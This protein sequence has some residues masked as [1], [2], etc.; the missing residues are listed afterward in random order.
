[1]NHKLISAGVLIFACL[2]ILATGRVNI[3]NFEKVQSSLEQM[4]ED[5]LVVKGL[6]FDLSAH[7]HKKEIA[8]LTGDKTFFESENRLVNSQIET[9]LKTFRETYLTKKEEIV[10]NEFSLVIDQLIALES[11]TGLDREQWPSPREVLRFQ[12]LLNE[13]KSQMKTLSG[14]QLAEGERKVRGGERAVASMQQ[15]ESLEL[16]SVGVLV[17]LVFVLLWIPSGSVKP[18]RIEGSSVE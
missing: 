13:L 2:L 17:L 3:R 9:H 5:R 12:S 18:E 6:L 7:L 11:R 16:F 15:I 4:F 10:L 1:M 14:I 8:L